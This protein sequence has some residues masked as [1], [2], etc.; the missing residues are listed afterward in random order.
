MFRHDPTHTGY[1]TE[2]ISLTALSR[3]WTFETGNVVIS[4]PAVANGKVF[5]GSDNHKIYALNEST[6]ELIWSHLSANKIISSPAVAASKVFVGSYSGLL[7]AF[8]ENDGT[9]AWGGWIPNLGGWIFSSPVVAYGMVFV[10]TSVDD[11]DGKLYAVDEDT[12]A[13][14]WDITF[15]GTP[16][17]SSPA[18]A[19]GMLFFGCDN[20]P[21]P[22]GK[23]YCLD[24]YTGEETW[25]YETGGGVVSSP[26]VVD[27]K[28]FVGSNDGSI[29][30]LDEQDTNEDKQGDL[31]WRYD[32]PRGGPVSSS[33]AVANGRVFVGCCDGYIYCLHEEKQS[34]SSQ[35]IWSTKVGCGTTSSCQMFSSPAVANGKVFV[36]SDDHYIYAFG[37]SATGIGVFRNGWWYV[38]KQDH[39]GTAY[40]FKYGISG[41][42]PVVGEIG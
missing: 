37:K 4:S 19:D 35:L 25:S 2:D 42:I 14:K 41:D 9:N 27:G 34:G 30:A 31:I 33:P 10:G 13:I 21:S 7:Y 28:V 20:Y 36:G 15:A 3:I 38:S 17:Y 22:T 6:G 1:T 24:A 26:T 8:N 39:S 12:G 23:I 16:I 18:V 11:V 32:T 29:Y 5:V 40:R